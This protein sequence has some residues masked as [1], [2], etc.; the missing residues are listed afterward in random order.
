[1]L[2]YLKKNIIQSE[3]QIGVNHVHQLL[4]HGINRKRC[5]NLGKVYVKTVGIFDMFYSGSQNQFV[6]Q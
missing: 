4:F 2:Q 3:S 5:T 6:M 1:M